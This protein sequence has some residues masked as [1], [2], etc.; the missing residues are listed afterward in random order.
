M[1]V[2]LETTCATHV[3]ALEQTAPL[4]GVPDAI[5]N[6]NSSVLASK[7]AIDAFFKAYNDTNTKLI[8]SARQAERIAVAASGNLLDRCGEVEAEGARFGRRCQARWGR[9]SDFFP[10]RLLIE[11]GT[12][13][14]AGSRSKNATGRSMWCWAR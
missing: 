13:T 8:S 5:N 11:P 4:A 1:L 10:Q 3:A 9:E 14:S 12:W 2:T 6:G 7:T